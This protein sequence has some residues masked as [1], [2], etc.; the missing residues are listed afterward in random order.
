MLDSVNRLNIFAQCRENRLAIWECPPFLFILMGIVNIITVVATYVFA[1]RLVDEPQA[2]ALIVIFVSVLIFIVGN[3]LIAGFN[4]IAE[5]NRL[6]SEFLNVVSHQLRT[7]LSVLRWSLELF[8]KEES[9][10]KSGSKYLAVLQDQS[11]RMVRLV[12]LL[13]DVSRIESKRFFLQRTPVSLEKLTTESLKS[14][15]PYADSSGITISFESKSK[16]ET[17]GDPERLRMVIQNLI[18]NAVRYSSAVGKV[19]ITLANMDGTNYVEWRI[20]DGGTGIPQREQQYIFQKYFRATNSRHSQTRGTGLGLYIAQTIVKELGG[21]IGFDS[22][23]GKGSTFWFRL[24]V[25]KK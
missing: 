22:E 16:A 2:A 24:P 20:K 12:N 7:P 13:I 19:D 4:R 23:E 3:L 11:E 6:K 9:V 17:L 25:Y 14:L 18:D 15:K 10:R 1:S 5:A 8:E 21:S